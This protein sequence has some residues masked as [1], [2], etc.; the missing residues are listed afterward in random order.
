MASLGSKHRWLNEA[1]CDNGHAVLLDIGP[2][3]TSL[4]HIFLVFDST[5]LPAWLGNARAHISRQFWFLWQNGFDPIGLLWLV[6]SSKIL[7]RDI[8]SIMFLAL[9]P[10]SFLRY[11]TIV[12]SAGG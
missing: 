2:V 6:V 12:H 1:F 11:D 3:C 5:F 7:Y 10:A 8:F 9:L 4:S